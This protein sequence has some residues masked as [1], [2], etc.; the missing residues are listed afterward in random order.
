MFN[1]ALVPIGFGVGVIS[2]LL[3]IGGGLILIPVLLATAASQYTVAQMTG[4]AAAQTLAAGVAATWV[5][6]RR[7]NMALPLLAFIA[8]SA[9]AGAY[10]GGW[11]S[12]RLPQTT[13]LALI[14]VVQSTNLVLFWQKKQRDHDDTPFNLDAI[15]KF[16]LCIASVGIGVLGGLF[17]LGGAIFLIP[18]LHAR[19]Q[20]P[21]NRAVGTAAGLVFV[22][23]IAACASKLVEN[24]ILP[25][26]GLVLAISAAAGAYLGARFSRRLPANALK[27]G[28]T[29]VMLWGIFQAGFAL[30]AH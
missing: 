6:F 20:M 25:L 3:G 14:I 12:A 23:A 17:G 8:P 9:M 24:L 18:L 15:P 30:I 29:G 26:P 21:M 19:W 27:I 1:I 7:K 5:H 13:L 2:G 10:A 11:L 28:L 22:T 16:K 4:L